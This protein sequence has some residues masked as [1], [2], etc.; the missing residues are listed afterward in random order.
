VSERTLTKPH[1]ASEPDEGRRPRPHRKVRVAGY[2]AGAVAAIVVVGLG[3]WLATVF[4]G[5]PSTND[6]VGGV[7]PG[8]PAQM[9]RPTVSE[10]GLVDR[11]GVKIVYVAVTGG[12]G[13][14]D[15]R[16]QVVDPDKAAAVH[17]KATPPAILDETT[18][19]VVNSLLMGH[20][21]TGEF[22][23]GVTYYLVFE[24]PG[25]LVQRGRQVSVLLGDA[26]VRHVPVQ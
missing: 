11:A 20:S 12:G 6:R 3:F 19:V 14:I 17:D 2:A 5:D 24:N 18:G 15:L 22:K 10:A 26:L 4:K 8:L 16:F 9:R 25:N 23:S 13:L 1:P 21:H 7:D